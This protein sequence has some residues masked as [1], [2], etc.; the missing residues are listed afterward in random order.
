MLTSS[1]HMHI[2]GTCTWTHMHTYIPIEYFHVLACINACYN[3]NWGYFLYV[4]YA[5]TI[6]CSNK[7]ISLREDPNKLSPQSSLY[8]AW[9]SSCQLTEFLFWPTSSM[10]GFWGQKPLLTQLQLVAPRSMSLVPSTLLLCCTSSNRYSLQV[11]PTLLYACVK[12]REVGNK[13]IYAWD[14]QSSCR[15][16]HIIQV[17]LTTCRWL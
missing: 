17:C 3:V 14:G 2:L 4:I 1:L 13:M 10:S 15:T 12:K 8:I 5:H 16:G 7:E 9:N 6:P 11:C